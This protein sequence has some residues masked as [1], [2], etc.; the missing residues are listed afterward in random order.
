MHDNDGTDGD[1]STEPSADVMMER[2]KYSF[3]LG[4]SMRKTALYLVVIISLVIVTFLMASSSSPTG[5]AVIPV[6]HASL[7]SSVQEV[8]VADLP[9]FDSDHGDNPS[10]KGATRGYLASRS[11]RITMVDSCASAKT[12]LEHSCNEVTKV[13]QSRI[14][15][16]PSRNLCYR[17]ACVLRDDLPHTC[18]EVKAGVVKGP[19][20]GRFNKYTSYCEDNLHLVYYSCEDDYAVQKEIIKCDGEYD[21]YGCDR[22]ACR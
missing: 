11:E 7:P 2:V 10:I 22:G 15:S 5:F 18:R 3:Y 20:N 19:L 17:G 8:F 6:F 14:R 12:V 4:E 9:C 13:I 1:N 21:Y 16:C